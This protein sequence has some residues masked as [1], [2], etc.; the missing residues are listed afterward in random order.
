MTCKVRSE[1]QEVNLKFQ[2]IYVLAS[3]SSLHQ[4]V[5][6]SCPLLRTYALPAQHSKLLKDQLQ[7]AE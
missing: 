3:S 6:R 7:L 4:M 1:Q 5:K 2:I